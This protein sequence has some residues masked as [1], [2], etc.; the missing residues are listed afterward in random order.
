MNPAQPSFYI[1]GGTLTLE[2]DSYL[3][4][5]ADKELLAALRAGEY[6]FVLNA[7]QMGKS[8]L[9]VRV[10]QQ[11]SEEGVQTVF[12]DLQKFG[13]ANVTPEQWYLSLLSEVGRSL[14]LRREFLVYW[15]EHEGYTLTRRFFGALREVALEQIETSIV[16]FVDEIDATRSLP[17]STDEFFAAM[18]E[19]YN[20]RIQDPA[21]GRITFCLVGSALPSD[22]IQDRRT[23]PFNIGERIELRDFTEEEIRPLAEGLDGPNTPAVL[24]RVFYWTNGHPYL[25]QS[26]C[27]EIE[28][29]DSIQTPKGVDR[30]VERLFFEA[31]ARERNINLADVANRILGSPGE[32]QT[33][34]EYRAETLDLYRKVL[35]GQEVVDD[36]A[37]RRGGVLKLSGVTRSVDGYLRLRNRIY[38]RVFD[39]QWV[40]ES[41]PDA[42]VRRQKAA[43]RRG[44]L[45][46]ASVAALVLA[47]IG[48]LAGVAARNARR[49]ES[50]AMEAK[51][52]A[53]RADVAAYEARRERDRAKHQLY[54]ADMNLAQKAYEENNLALVLELLE[55]HREAPERGI[56]WRYLWRQCRLDLHTLI[57]HTRWVDRVAFSPDGR[58]IV[59]TSGDQTAKVWEAQTGRE[60]RTLQGHTGTIIG[61]AFSPDGHRI[62]TGSG[63]QTAKVWEAQTGRELLTLQGHAGPVSAVAFSPDGRWIVTGSYDQT[64]KVW[65][66][67]TGRELRTLRGHT[68]RVIGVAFSPDGRKIVT[69]SWDQTAK[70]WE[71]QTGRELLTLQGHTAGVG[72]VAFSPDG[73]WIMTASNDNTAK[74]WEAQTGRELRTL[75]G[76]TGWLTSVAFSPDG[77]RIV[78]GSSDNTV[79][80]WEAQT[81][82]ELLTLQG[83]TGPVL[84]AAFSSDGH[85]IVTGSYDR[86]V[87]VWE[88]QTGRELRTLRGHTARVIGV[89]FSPDGR[90]IVTGSW[91]QTAKVWE[92]QTGRE[93]LTLQGHTAGVGAVAFSPD[94]RWIMT[95]SND[96]T[97]KVWEA[98]TGRELRTLRGHTGWLTSVAFSPDGS[99]IVTGSSDNTVKVWEAQTGREL[100]TLQGHTGPV[101]AAAFS[102]DGHRIVT[103]SEDGT[104]KVWESASEQQITAWRQDQQRMAQLKDAGLARVEKEAARRQRIL[105]DSKTEEGSIKRWLL[106][107]P[108]PIA[109]GQTGEQALDHTQLPGEAH[110]QPRAGDKVHLKGH[111][112]TWQELQLK[113]FLIDLNSVLEP[114]SDRVVAYAVSY[115][116][117]DREQE[118]LQI[119]MGSE[120]QAKIYLNGKKVFRRAYIGGCNPDDCIIEDI[121]LRQGVNRVV[122]KVVNG[123]GGAWQ[124]CLRFTDGAGNPVEGLQIQL[125]P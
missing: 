117:S 108:I 57:G 74:V 24:Q 36:E 73:R 5:A 44:L 110:L 10:M 98:Q 102:S 95:A 8:S 46:M 62:V 109:P 87:K 29:N 112:F 28:A 86:T 4:R 77:S 49:A 60:L 92:A 106:L 51:L 61:V 37:D 11:L 103:A 42:E 67:Q 34:E 6:C 121:T 45:R 55:Q 13:G 21:S 53:Q 22:L 82:R 14:G 80:V 41:L 23:S 35:R 30:V 26:L 17:F 93:L 113:E 43:Y 33:E 12:V 104:T 125:Y 59:T 64:V 54:I 81:G 99:R 107:G 63:D 40:Q 90:K 47:I 71:A 120:N 50:N 18:R 116:R 65:E 72:A 88:A 119:R 118:S 122:F 19:F 48:T 15:K 70:V 31:Q 3:E 96:N 105:A 75:R 91:D 52:E 32:G 39:R 76:H 89:A 66:A 101:L 68:A 1:T 69:G 114:K 20:T 16:I 7:R 84:A 111:P 78:T 25:T 83:H 56:E 58:W 79:K 94:G 85:W 38:E 27:A 123:G 2:A 115:V 97:A 100:L 124:G 9:S